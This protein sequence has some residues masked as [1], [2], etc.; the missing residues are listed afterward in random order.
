MEK[1]EKLWLYVDE[2][3]KEHYLAILNIANKVDEVIDHLNQ[4][5]LCVEPIE[6]IESEILKLE[7]RKLELE[8]ELEKLKHKE[9][10]QPTISVGDILPTPLETFS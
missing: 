8:V 7:I 5:Q 1:I 9:Y 10:W 6:P 2:I 3:E 4:D